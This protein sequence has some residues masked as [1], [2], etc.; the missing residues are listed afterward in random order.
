MSDGVGWHDFVA[1]ERRRPC[2]QG[3]VPPPERFAVIGSPFAVKRARMTIERLR[4]AYDA[5][6]FIPFVL[7]LADGRGIPVR[8]REFVVPAPSGRTI[9]VFQPDN[10]MNVIDLLLVT[11]LEFQRG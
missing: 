11:D 8:S 9:G 7:H 10:R 6:P 5:Q 4:E 2:V 3:K 1:L